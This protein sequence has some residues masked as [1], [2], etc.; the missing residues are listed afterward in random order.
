MRMEEAIEAVPP[1]LLLLV[2]I[3][4]QIEELRTEGLMRHTKKKEDP[5]VELVQLSDLIR[6]TM[7]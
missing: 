4:R 1:L 7:I 6:T 5:V 2:M 3:M